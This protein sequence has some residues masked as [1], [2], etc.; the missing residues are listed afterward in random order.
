MSRRVFVEIG[1]RAVVV[2]GLDDREVQAALRVR[3]KEHAGRPVQAGPHKTM[4]L[5]HCLDGGQAL[6]EEITMRLRDYPL[7]RGEREALKRAEKRVK[8]ALR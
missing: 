8:A 7:E 5:F 2:L 6:H 1:D 4:T 3:R